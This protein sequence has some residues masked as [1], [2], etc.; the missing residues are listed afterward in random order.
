MKKILFLIIGILSTLTVFSQNSQHNHEINRRIEFPDIDGY[1]TLI[2]DF[3]QHS[4][5]SDGN[6]WPSIRVQES[7]KDGLDV[8]SI[9]DHLEYQPH[10][11]DIP[12]PDRNRSYQIALDEVEDHDLI[13]I[14]GSEI[15][16]SMPPGH[17]NA[18]FIKDANKLLLDDATDVF[19]EANKQGAFVFWNHPNWTSQRKDGLATLTDMHKQLISQKLL[20]GIEVANGKDYSEEALKI[21][22]DNDLTLIGASDI[23]GL[24][25]WDYE[26]HDGG[27]RPIT[28]VFA[29][30]KSKEGIHNALFNKQTVVYFNNLLIGRSEFLTPLIQSSLIIEKAEYRK[31]SMVLKITINNKSNTEF[32]LKNNSK[33]TFHNYSDIVH[34]EPKQSTILEVKTLKILSS[35]ELEFEVLNGIVAPKTHPKFLLKTAIE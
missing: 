7:L 27:H 26:V 2:C 14:K 1:K 11:K 34:I 16:R 21:A 12:H 22:L 13:V 32:I 31:N 24:I 4:V 18:I 17:S 9:T 15:T 35:L 6:V 29:K 30:E 19:K 20:H 8:M 5:F 33:F 23:H 25:D 28:L 3:H 10:L